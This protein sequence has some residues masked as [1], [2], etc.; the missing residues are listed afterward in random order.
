[1]V[2]CLLVLDMVFF[3]LGDSREKKLFGGIVLDRW[4]E[5]ANLRVNIGGTKNRG[6][7]DG[8]SAGLGTTQYLILVLDMM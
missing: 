2:R 7:M 4:R 5:N 1:M 6:C 3:V 8:E